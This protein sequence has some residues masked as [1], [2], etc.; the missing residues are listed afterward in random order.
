MSYAKFNTSEQAQ[1]YADKVQE[2]L[3]ADSSYIAESWSV[4][5]Q[6]ETSWY[7]DYFDGVETSAEIV[8]DLPPLPE[9]SI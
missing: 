3:S 8:A 2:I 5:V 9:N 7:V 1:N 6:R 4:P